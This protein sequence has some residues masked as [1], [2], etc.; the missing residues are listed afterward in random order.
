M[1][2][3][4]H[5]QATRDPQGFLRREMGLT[6]IAGGNVWVTDAEIRLREHLRGLD[7]TRRRILYLQ[8]A[9]DERIQKNRIL[10]ETNS[11][12]IES[13]RKTLSSS[14]LDAAERKR[15]EEQIKELKAQAVKPGLLPAAPDV[16]TRVIELSNLRHRL[17]LSVIAIRRLKPQMD[18]DYERLA[19]D[20]DVAAALSRLGGSHQLGPMM[21]GYVNHIRRLD[22]YEQVVFTA[23]SPLYIQSGRIR[24]GAILNEQTPVTFSWQT[25][26]EPTVLTAAMVEAAQLTMPDSA[27]TIQMAFGRRRLTVRRIIVPTVRFGGLVLRDV[28]AY[29]LPPEGEH[30]G[31]RIGSEG[32]AECQVAVEP[33]RLRLVIQRR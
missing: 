24:L 25:S 12:R 11:R 4:A 5:A 28:P 33:E 21:G 27:E 20:E 13:L 3:T 18:A 23:W 15:T 22:E 14:K 30:L 7:G 1:S 10:W 6:K 16:R 2:V 29:V 32:L 9:L 8:K 19:Q 31:A 17:T 26:A